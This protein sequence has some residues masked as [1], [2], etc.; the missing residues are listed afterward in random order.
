MRGGERWLNGVLSTPRDA[1]MKKRMV[2]MIFPCTLYAN[3]GDPHFLG[4]KKAHKHRICKKNDNCHIDS[5][6]G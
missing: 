5:E 6:D 4:L 1:H 3:A 2:G